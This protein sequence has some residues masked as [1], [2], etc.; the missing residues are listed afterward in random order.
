MGYYLKKKLSRTECL[1]QV[2]MRQMSQVEFDDLET[3]NLMTGKGRQY[4]SRVIRD[5]RGRMVLHNKP[6]FRLSGGKKNGGGIT[7]K[8]EDYS[9]EM[10]KHVDT[11]MNNWQLISEPHTRIVIKK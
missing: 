2:E 10:K 5:V 3:K 1:R 11:T 6:S 7:V 4:S 8:E 9:D